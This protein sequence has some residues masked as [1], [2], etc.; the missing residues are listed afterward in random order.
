MRKMQSRWRII[1]TQNEFFLPICEEN[2]FF[3]Q[4]LSSSPLGSEYII[5]KPPVQRNT[6]AERII[7]ARVNFPVTAIYAAIGAMDSPSAKIR[8]RN[9]VKRFV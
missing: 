8:W 4:L 1:D 5:S 2:E 6:I 7:G 9:H 3:S